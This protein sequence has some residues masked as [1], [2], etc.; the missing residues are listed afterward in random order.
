VTINPAFFFVGLLA[1]IYLIWANERLRKV[2]IAVFVFVFVVNIMKDHPGIVT[3][4][5]GKTI[6]PVTNLAH[7]CQE[8]MKEGS[9]TCDISLKP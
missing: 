2:F 8:K 9:N 4:A 3:E 6:S 1:V 5:F 7:H